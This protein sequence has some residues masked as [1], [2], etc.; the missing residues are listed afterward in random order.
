MWERAG[1]R[2]CVCMRKGVSACMLMNFYVDLKDKS[3]MCKYAHTIPHICLYVY[4][5]T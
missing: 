2:A 3:I 4:V 5:S 1:V